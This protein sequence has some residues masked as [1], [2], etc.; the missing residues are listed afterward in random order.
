MSWLITP[1]HLEKIDT[2]IEGLPE[3]D[4][5][6]ISI[7]LEKLIDTIYKDIPEK[8]R[9]STGRYSIVKT[10]G[11]E[12]YPRLREAGIDLQEFAAGIYENNDIDRFVRSLGVQLYALYGMETSDL[13]TVHLIFETAAG[14]EDWI[15]RECS[16]GF[17]RK[18]VKKYP[19]E[20]KSWYLEM[21]YSD[22][23]HQRRFVSESLRPVVENRW[24]HK[25]PD[26]ALGI[27][28]NLFFESAPYPRTSV[29]NNMSD[30]MRVN[31]EVAWPIVVELARNGDKNSYWIA[32][33]ACRNYVKK[34]PLKVLELL[35]VEEY[36][37]KTR[38]HR[39]ED[40][41]NH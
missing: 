32:Y 7:E 29:G 38:I 39:K 30:W 17:I 8:K 25:C 10:L 35:E 3:S 36:K 33:R 2:F 27:I 16:S 28:K 4:I 14:D 24:F 20:M 41:Q 6:V 13:D 40:Y 12:L 15:V 23:P 19:D 37:Y 1:H 34:E 21:V 9:I 26:Y 11:Q 31:Q 5:S 18:L 22:D